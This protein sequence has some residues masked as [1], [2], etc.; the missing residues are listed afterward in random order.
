MID[1][2]EEMSATGEA[3]DAFIAEWRDAQAS[4]RSNAQKFLIGLTQLVGAEVPGAATGDV[5]RDAY[6]FERPVRFHDGPTASV[7]FADLYKRGAVVLE[8]K[9][10]VDAERAA[11][12]RRQRKGHGVRGTG[13]WEATMEAAKNQAARY[14][15]NLEPAEPVPPFLAVVDVGYCVDLYADFGG[16]GRLYAPDAY[17][18]GELGA[19]RPR[20]RILRALARERRVGRL[21]AVSTFLHAEGADWIAVPYGEDEVGMAGA[22]RSSEMNDLEITTAGRYRERP[23]QWLGAGCAEA[24]AAAHFGRFPLVTCCDLTR[25][26]ARRISPSVEL[27]DGSS[28]LHSARQRRRVS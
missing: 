28:L 15:R 25:R 8:T 13:A 3:V 2:N 27:F 14:A 22:L 5:R 24:L 12:G 10:G 23:P 21:G 17:D 26:V 9:Q 20:C 16:T 18:P 19:P 4:E 7:G 6:V 1:A 11:Q